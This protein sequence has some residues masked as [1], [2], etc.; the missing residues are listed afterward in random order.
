MFDISRTVELV[1]GMLFQ[2][3]QTWQAYLADNKSW[4]ETLI[5]LALPLVAGSLLI[6]FILSFLFPGV[7]SLGLG[8]LILSLITGVL[9]LFVSAFILGFLASLF[10]G[11]NDFDRAFAALTLTG[12]PAYA[13]MAISGLPF[14][15]WLLMLLAAIYSLVLLYQIIPEALGV[16]DD[17]RV[18]HFV[19]FLIAA[20]IAMLVLNVLLLPISGPLLFGS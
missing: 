10:K 20:V 6:S 8:G 5:E 12:V 3:Q 9:A 7:L 2:P 17:R 18:T 4:R 1:K 11:R 16:P 14:I 15:G 13:G 19:S